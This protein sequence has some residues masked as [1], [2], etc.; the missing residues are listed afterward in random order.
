MSIVIHYTSAHLNITAD[1][2][3]GKLF[4]VATPIGNL[5]DISHRAIDTICQCD[6]ILAES[7]ERTSKLL[8]KF[9]IDKKIVTFNKDNEKRKVGKIINDLV[10]GKRVALLSDAGT[11]A[12]S[13]PAFELVRHHGNGFEISP[14][15]GPSALTSALSISPIPINNF[16]FLGF[17]PKK[18]IEIQKRLN[19]V[20]SLLFPVVIFENKNRLEKIINIVSREFGHETKICIFREISKIHEEIKCGMAKTLINNFDKIKLSG[21]FTI[22]IDKMEKNQSEISDLTDKVEVLSKNYSTKEIVNILS[23]FANFSKKDLYNF[24]LSIRQER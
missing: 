9:N 19:E 8:S 14:I 11:P 18:E 21:E 10:N 13:D 3:T 15:P 23:L 7:S 4:I 20:K 12:I 6:Y 5:D 24:V 2:M 1:A 17:L 22:I 16:I